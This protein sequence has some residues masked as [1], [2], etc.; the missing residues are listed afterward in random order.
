MDFGLRNDIRITE[1]LQTPLNQQE[2]LRVKHQDVS[3]SK[4][5]FSVHLR[6]T[7]VSMRVSQNA[8][9]RL[10]VASHCPF[11]VWE[12]KSDTGVYLQLK[13]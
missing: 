4:G 2:P 6:N 1:L 7:D 5:H 8:L 12:K 3:G 11:V 9:D 10:S 13:M